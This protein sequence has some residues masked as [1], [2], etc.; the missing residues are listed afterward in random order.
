VVG[1]TGVE[2]VCFG[3]ATLEAGVC[4]TVTGAAGAIGASAVRD[5]G[6]VARRRAARLGGFGPAGA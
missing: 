5:G 6:G 1:G 2:E 4:C 3:W